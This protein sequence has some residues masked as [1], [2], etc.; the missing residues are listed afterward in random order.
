[1][2]E[3]LFW[4]A[5]NNHSLLP[6]KKKI[7]VFSLSPY[8]AFFLFLE[9]MLIKAKIGLDKVKHW[10]GRPFFQVCRREGRAQAEF[11]SVTKDGGVL[12][13]T[14][15]GNLDHSC[16][17]DTRNP[18]KGKAGFWYLYDMTRSTAWSK[19]PSKFRL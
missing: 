18:P 10:R 16:H 6:P 2:R 14:A 7:Y 1:M 19:A 8:G 13:M 4:Y 5:K 11:N 9:L 15:R 12:S 3:D 17:R